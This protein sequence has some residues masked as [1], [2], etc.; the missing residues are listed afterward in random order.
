MSAK[1]A[2]ALSFVALSG[3]ATH[4]VVWRKHGASHHQADA[5]RAQCAYEADMRLATYQGQRY[6]AA[7]SPGEALVQGIA[8]GLDFE[9]RKATLVQSCM[10]ARG[11]VA[12]AIDGPAPAP[13]PAAFVQPSAPSG[14]AAQ[15]PPPYAVQ[16]ATYSDPRSRM[17]APAEPPAP[18]HPSFTQ[19]QWAFVVEKMAKAEKCEPKENAKIITSGPGFEHYSVSCADGEALAVRCDHGNCRVL[20]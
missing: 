3:C 14:D 18:P 16:P 8:I 13:P 19:G 7:R 2:V 15:A 20:K 6:P 5:E 12:V 17:N 1:F 11:Y 10:R 9:M 4:D